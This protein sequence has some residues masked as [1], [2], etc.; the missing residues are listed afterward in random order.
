[1]RSNSKH[2]SEGFAQAIF[3][4]KKNTRHREDEANKLKT[5]LIRLQQLQKRNNIVDVD[6][7][8][9]YICI[10]EVHED[11]TFFL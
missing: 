11:L 3:D 4:C 2:R 1:M 8:F 9:I 10:F 6:V 7:S 5:Q